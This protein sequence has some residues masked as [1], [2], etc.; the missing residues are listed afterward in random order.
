MLVGLSVILVLFFG[1]GL[2]KSKSGVVVAHKAP[3][4]QVVPAREHSN[5]M[6]GTPDIAVFRPCVHQVFGSLLG[7]KSTY[8]AWG[9]VDAVFITHFQDKSGLYE[10]RKTLMLEQL[11]QMLPKGAWEDSGFVRFITEFSGPD[12][13]PEQ[14]ACFVE[15]NKC[16]RPGTLSQSMKHYLAHYVAAAHGYERYFIFEDDLL[17][18]PAFVDL[19]Q[20]TVAHLDAHPLGPYVQADPQDLQQPKTVVLRNA[21]C[22]WDM[23]MFGGCKHVECPLQALALAPVCIAQQ[24][25]PSRCAYAGLFHQ[26]GGK[27]MLQKAIEYQ[28]DWQ[29]DVVSKHVKPFEGFWTVD[30]V[31]IEDHSRLKNKARGTWNAD[32]AGA[33]RDCLAEIRDSDYPTVHKVHAAGKCRC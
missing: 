13:S 2:R 12:I 15:D 25:R 17:F 22:P 14:F 20:K 9:V 11:G 23:V 30:M 31:A 16:V 5:N 27:K 19:L 1:M 6:V 4:E 26:R 21:S 28:S 10:E 33:K 7:K 24:G 3:D 29:M 32:A 18:R 8:R